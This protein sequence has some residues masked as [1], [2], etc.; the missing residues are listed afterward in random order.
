MA[1][2]QAWFTYRQMVEA[3]QQLCAAKRSGTLSCTNR[4][5]V[6][7]TIGLR[8]GNIIALGFKDKHGVSVLPFVRLMQDCQFHFAENVVQPPEDGLPDTA[9]ILRRLG[10]AASPPS[11]AV[12]SR[13]SGTL[14][15]APKIIEEEARQA[16]GPIGALLCAE[17]LTHTGQPQDL[18]AVERMLAAIVA[19]IGEAGRTTAFRQRVLDRLRAERVP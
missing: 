8:Q 4:T 9:D 12:V 11:P 19:K 2:E 5:N 6:P 3:L 1:N 17:Y 16:F 7:V 10:A 14:S 18:N 15:Q 13:P